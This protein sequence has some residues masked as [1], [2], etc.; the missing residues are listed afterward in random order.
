MITV[1][2]QP[3]VYW[4]SLCGLGRWCRLNGGRDKR[5]IVGQQKEEFCKRPSYPKKRQPRKS[6][7][8]EAYKTQNR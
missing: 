2:R 7:L 1:C 4:D 8:S 5:M 6:S 3:S